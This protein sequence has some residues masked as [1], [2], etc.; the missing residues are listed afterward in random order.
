MVELLVLVLMYNLQVVILN[1]V[2]LQ[3]QYLSIMVMDIVQ[4]YVPVIRDVR[5]IWTIMVWMVHIGM[6]GIVVVIGFVVGPVI[7]VVGVVLQVVVLT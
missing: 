1:H 4:R 7:V 2:V 6:V 3:K 5:H